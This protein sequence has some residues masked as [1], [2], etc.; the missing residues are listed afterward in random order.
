MDKIQ[1]LPDTVANLIAAGEV[2][3][4]P[5]SVIKELMEN[6][7]DAGATQIDVLVIEAGR[8]SIQV[9]DNGVG[10]SVTDARLAF[11]RHATSKIRKADD[12]FS[13]ETMGF[14]GEALPSI[15]SV[16][17]VTLKTRQEDDTVGISL[18]IDGGR[19]VSQTPV[20]CS[21]GCHFIV[22]NIFYNVPVRRRFLKSNTTELNN[23]VSAFQ[24]IALVYPQIGFTLQ[25][26]NQK[27]FDLRA[28]SLHQRIVD[29]FGK[30]LKQHLLP[31]DVETTLGKIEGFVGKPESARKKGAQQYFFV[32]GRFMRHPYFQ[33]AVME[34]YER[35]VPQGE[36][37]PFFIY[38]TVDPKDIDVNIHP[39]KTEIKFQDEQALW[40]ILSAAV[41]EAVGRFSNIPSIDFDTEGKL[42]MPVFEEMENISMP[43]IAINTQY[44]PFKETTSHGDSGTRDHKQSVPS[45]WSSLYDNA[46]SGQD[47]VETEI[48]SSIFDDDLFGDSEENMS[49]KASDTAPDI[50]S[51]FQYKGSYI[52]TSV[53]QGLMVIDQERAHERIL[54]ERYEES[55]ASGKHTSQPLLFPEKIQFSVA[56]MVILP[57]IIPQLESLGFDFSDLGGGTYAINA[58]PG[59]LSS[60]NAAK[61]VT[62]TVEAAEDTELSGKSLYSSLAATMAR[63]SA[64]PHGQVLSED[65]M[66]NLVRD[67]FQCSNSNYTPSGKKIHATLRHD[68]LLHMLG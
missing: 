24:R 3:Q 49:S 60:I 22:D 14:R 37:V 10:M 19:F 61:V 17:Q 44:N 33:K 9:V 4:R 68:N 66:R 23:V 28:S 43:S 51:C 54:F 59:E 42:D 2:V 48:H 31:L 7:I 13:L 53:P 45:D 25:S 5:A 55:L 16:A 57:T 62:Q 15:A 26:N 27:L 35:L 47:V 64:I 32:N 65:E 38:F 30:K 1:L 58:V 11:E 41:R 52:L 39:T 50:S 21:K 40:Q 63:N 36:Q 46:I 29:V 34:A 6:A 12:L 18:R 67:L 56:E 20:A 8:T